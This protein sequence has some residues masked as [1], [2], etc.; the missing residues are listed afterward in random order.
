MPNPADNNYQALREQNRITVATGQSNTDATQSLP[1]KIDSI[2]GRLLVSNG[3]SS[4]TGVYNE[5]VSGSGTAWTLANTPILA[6]Q[7]IYADGQRLTPTMDYSIS[8]TSITTVLSWLA[9]TVLAD[10]VK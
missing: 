3:G 1:F 6:T 5:V 10:Y 4:G 7:A 8:G 2:T 9:G